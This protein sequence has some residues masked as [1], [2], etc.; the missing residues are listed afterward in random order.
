MGLSFGWKANDIRESI[1][2]DD[3]TLRGPDGKSRVSAAALDAWRTDG[4]ASHLRPFCEGEPQIITFRNLTID[5][6]ELVR[7]FF[8][9]DAVEAETAI[10]RAFL[11]CFR[12][13]VDFGG[14]EDQIDVD[15]ARRKLIVR[16][17]GVRMLAE[18][19]VAHLERAYPGIVGFYGGL[20]FNASM[21]SPAEKK[22]SSPPSTQTP[23]SA[24]ASTQDTTGAS[25][26]AGAASG[27]P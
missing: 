21:P 19:F 7:S 26:S 20:I 25:P 23:S 8:R 24:A 10:S 1:W 5:E 13:G 4:D 16:E 2:K 22:A 6:F 12:L 18:P 27:A 14:K 15:G 17:N 9:G 11:L 3:T